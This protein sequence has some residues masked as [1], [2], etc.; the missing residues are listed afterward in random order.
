MR[1]RDLIA[2]LLRGTMADCAARGCKT[3]SAHWA[4][5][6]APT[7]NH[8]PGLAFADVMQRAIPIEP[9]SSPVAAL[10]LE[11]RFTVAI[12]R[13]RRPSQLVCAQGDR[14]MTL[15]CYPT[16]GGRKLI[17]SIP[18]DPRWDGARGLPL[19][20]DAVACLQR[21]IAD[22]VQARGFEPIFAPR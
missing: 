1:N 8:S 11:P 16:F 17:V 18:G 4:I 21:A 6:R 5:R 13:A 19:D 22:E 20:D 9:V 2:R 7:W 3:G 10:A 14:R 12:Q 15:L